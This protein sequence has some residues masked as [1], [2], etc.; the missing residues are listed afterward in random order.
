MDTIDTLES[1]G[2]IKTGHPADEHEFCPKCGMCIE[3]GDCAIWGA[4]E[5][6]STH[7]RK[8]NARYNKFGNASPMD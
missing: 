5:N 8:T 7:K 3:C 1:D 2:T 6:P 4:V